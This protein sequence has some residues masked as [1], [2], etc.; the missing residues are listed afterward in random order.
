MKPEIIAREALRYTLG[1]TAF[2]AGLDKFFNLLTNWEKYISPVARENLP[3]SDRNFMRL[4]GVIEMAVG[5]LILKG[6]SR[7][8]G[9]VAGGWLLAIAANLVANRDYDIAARDVNMAVGAI[10]LAQLSEARRARAGG[11]RPAERLRAA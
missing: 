3:V 4:A 7:I 1:G 2:V 8:G 11:E 5:A 6:E 9:Y 10:A